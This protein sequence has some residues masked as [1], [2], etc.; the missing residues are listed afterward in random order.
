MQD[1]SQGCPFCLKEKL[2][3]KKS[4]NKDVIKTTRGLYK[5][6]IASN[7]CY[8]LT[9]LEEKNITRIKGKII[10]RRKITTY[11]RYVYGLD[12]IPEGWVIWH[13]D[14][15]P[16]NNNIENLECISRKE[17]MIRICKNKDNK[18]P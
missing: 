3:E 18:K 13:I 14:G 12:R 1:R 4:R 11:A 17:L 7:N 15:D 9:S 2:G 10:E 8:V 16:F 6:I 5:P